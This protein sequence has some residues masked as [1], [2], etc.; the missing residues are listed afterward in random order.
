MTPCICPKCGA[1]IYWV[2]AAFSG[3]LVAVNAAPK[4]DGAAPSAEDRGSWSNWQAH[5]ATCG[6]G[7]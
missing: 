1:S 3:H 2:K 7:K 6:G 5:R 4:L